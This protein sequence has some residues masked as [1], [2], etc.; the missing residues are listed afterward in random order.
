MTSA[1]KY[2]FLAAGAFLLVGSALAVGIA[3]QDDSRLAAGLR[4]GNVEI[5]GLRSK[6]A[7]KLLQ[8]SYGKPAQL[9]VKAGGRTWLVNA[10]KLGWSYDAETT[11]TAATQYTNQRNPL[12]RI[13]A[14]LQ[15]LTNSTPQR[16]YQPVY[17]IEK[18]QA[19]K[20]LNEIT[21]DINREPRDATVGFD[22]A[23]KRYAVIEKD[24]NGQKVDIE[25][26]IKAYLADPTQQ[27]LN[28]PVVT[29]AAQLVAEKLQEHADQGNAMMRPLTITLA[30]SK[31]KI[32]LSP[33]Q[34][35]NFYWVKNQGIVMDDK[36]IQKTFQQVKK[37]V[38]HPARSARY[39][40][41][42]GAFVV[43]P[44]RTGYAIDSKP[45]Y[46]AFYKAIKDVS[47]NSVE[48]PS[49]VSQPAVTTANLPDPK[50]LELISRG[51]SNYYGSS[52]DRRR[53]IA[54]A[55]RKIDGTVVGK[56]ENFSFLQ[57]VGGITRANGFG[58]GLIISGGRTI[59]G[60]GGG[61]CQ[62]S[63]TAFRAMYNAGL[64]VIERNQHSYRVK[65]YEP[66]VGFEA[67]VYDPGVDLRMKNDT[68]APILVRAFNNNARS[69]L[70]VQIWGIKPKRTVRV[71]RAR[72]L[73]STPNPPAKTIINPRLPKGAVRQVDW[74][75]RG[76]VMYITR[77]IKDANGARYDR[78]D[79]NYRPWQAVYERGP[80]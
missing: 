45:A 29:W 43:V 58:G 37:R 31:N 22:R 67:A 42:K 48:L 76:Y 3:T 68:A 18:E 23:S 77:T 65:Y 40:W 32:T 6:Q 55:A 36:A 80:S 33:L 5:G 74:A 78:V 51:T 12:E 70:E 47:K 53:N 21:K 38:E 8:D 56:G 13:Q 24:I 39:A 52:G 49:I 44:E 9:T 63:T 79:T 15:Q 7:L 46:Q 64:P 4:V 62:V 66:K 35:A 27:V 73:S 50:N 30:K 72:I 75:Q 2:S 16:V 26:A 28:V 14:S 71:S 57:A 11:I 34:L 69:Y 60:L 59:D 20:V 61:V 25:A 54:N 41:Q 10:A 19:R 17:R 1:M